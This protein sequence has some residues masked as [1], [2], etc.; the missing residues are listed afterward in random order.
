MYCASA[1]RA[2]G[3]WI[4]GVADPASRCGSQK[5]GQ[6]ILDEYLECG[7][8]LTLANNAVEAGILKVWSRMSTGRL[9]VFRSLIPWF[10]EF[11]IY[12]RDENGKVVKSGD[13]LMDATHYLVVSGIAA[14]HLDPAYLQRMGHKGGG[15][16]HEYNPIGEEAFAA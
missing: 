7:L 5:D 9:K 13:H 15:V 3:D 1:I 12:R 11:R 6:K 2:R 16:V 14:M 10:N 4:P 8:H